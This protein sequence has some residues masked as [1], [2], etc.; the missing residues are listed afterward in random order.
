MTETDGSTP[1]RVSLGSDHPVWDRFFQVSPLVVIG[2]IE[3]SGEIDLAPKHMAMP[4]GWDN[5]FGFMC[6][7]AHATYGNAVRT[8][9]F[10]VSVP[11]PSQIVL[12]SLAAAPRCDDASKP[13]LA[14]LETIP[15]TRV[16]GALLAE[17]SLHLECRLHRVYDDFGEHSLITGAVVEA[18][19]DEA[20]IRRSD[21][22]D[23]QLIFEAPLLAYLN[24]GRYAPVTHSF[25]FPF[26]EGWSR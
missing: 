11:R 1:R 9:E 15:A 23:E 14:L 17:A 12:A 4:M 24:P 25:A 3:E 26:H 5:Y 18:H 6:T 19:V 20:S 2:T 8:G 7:P 10:T 16:Q 13:A 21:R 22:D